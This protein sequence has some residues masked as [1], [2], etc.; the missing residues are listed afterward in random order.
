MELAT[1]FPSGLVR[2][3]A[4]TD[5]FVGDGPR[6]LFAF[7]KGTLRIVI[8]SNDREL[9]AVRETR[10]PQALAA[11]CAGL[12][13]RGYRLSCISRILATAVAL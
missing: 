5:E 10:P 3:P 1:D 9:D 12:T 6:L 7:G 2:S 11:G 8:T 13:V 4:C